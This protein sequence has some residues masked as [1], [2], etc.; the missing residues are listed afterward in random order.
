MGWKTDCQYARRQGNRVE[1]IREAYLQAV[2]ALDILV[3]ILILNGAESVNCI[4]QRER[5]FAA[6]LLHD[7]G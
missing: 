3:N 2:V 5:Y 6:G 4:R 7:E 1:G